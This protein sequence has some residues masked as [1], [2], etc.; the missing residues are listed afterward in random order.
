MAPEKLFDRGRRVGGGVGDTEAAAEVQHRDR[1]AREQ[2]LMHVEEA[3]GRLAE[4][5]DAE[6]LRADVAVQAAEVEARQLAD[7]RHD[8]LG[9]GE[10]GAELLVFVGRREEVVG[11]GVH[12]AVD[13]QAHRL[14][15]AAACR[16][17]GDPLDLDVAVDDDRADADLDRA[18]DLGDRLVVAVEAD[19]RGVGAAGEGDGELLPRSRRRRPAL[20]RPPT[21]RP[22]WTGRPC[23]RSTPAP[24]CRAGRRPRR[25]PCEYAGRG[26]AP[27]PRRARTAACRTGRGGRSRRPRRGPA[28]RCRR[29]ARHPAT[30]AERGRSRHRAR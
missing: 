24:S 20:R 12:A 27:R 18:G 11:L 5:V 29:G 22:R 17:S 10:R 23:P 9:A 2:P 19:A 8:L 15:D 13:A 25:R 3:G 7:A 30:R 26:S 21:A 4:A 16:L 14:A 28:L 1:A 6:D